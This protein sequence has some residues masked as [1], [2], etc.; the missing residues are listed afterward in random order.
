MFVV[1][2]V[3]VATVNDKSPSVAAL[4]I[5]PEVKLVRTTL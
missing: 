4:T 2:N 3:F 1:F 5:S